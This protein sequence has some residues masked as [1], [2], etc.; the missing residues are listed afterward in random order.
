MFN[1][2]INRYSNYILKFHTTRA[3]SPFFQKSK[4]IK[5][6]MKYLFRGLFYLSRQNILTFKRSSGTLKTYFMAQKKIRSTHGKI[7]NRYTLINIPTFYK[8]S[9]F[10]M[11]VRDWYPFLFSIFPKLK[12][13]NFKYYW[14]SD[15]FKPIA[16][17]RSYFFTNYIKFFLNQRLVKQPMLLLYNK[18]TKNNMYTNYLRVFRGIV[19]K[20]PTNYIKFSKSLLFYVFPKFKSQSYFV[21]HILSL[22]KFTNLS[23]LKD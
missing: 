4:K 23:F 11:V 12:Y 13:T 21:R 8:S 14:A 19:L 10:K 18:T 7:R 17:S 15:F 2:N 9:K 3:F 6:N 5:K 1:H 20:K 16:T 22:K